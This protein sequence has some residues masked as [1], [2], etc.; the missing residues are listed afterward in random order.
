MGKFKTWPLDI[1][2]DVCS[3]GLYVE[4]GGGLGK[5]FDCATP[6][7]G[8]VSPIL[9]GGLSVAEISIGTPYTVYIHNK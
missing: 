5:K 8:G 1:G 3:H 7:G 4:T 6:G 2:N 9:L